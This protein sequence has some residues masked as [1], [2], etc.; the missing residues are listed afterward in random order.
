MRWRVGSKV[1]LNVYD[2]NGNLVCECQ[3]VAA[4]QTIVKTVNELAEHAALLGKLREALAIYADEKNWNCPRCGKRDNQNCF[5]GRWTGPV[6]PPKDPEFHMGEGHGYDTA[7]NAL[8]LLDSLSKP[9]EPLL[10]PATTEELASK[11]KTWFRPC[12]T[13]T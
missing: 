12:T 8:A 6:D 10:P 1:P 2:G 4:A 3:D 11:F 5:M 7:R 13:R 9:A